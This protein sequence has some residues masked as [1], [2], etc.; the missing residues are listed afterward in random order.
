MRI[1]FVVQRYGAQ[2][3]GGA[4]LAAREFATRLALRGHATEVLTSCAVS[5][6]DWANAYP[7]GTEELDGVLV[8]RLEV[9]E[10]R[11]DRIFG[12]MHARVPFGRHRVP[13]FMQRDWMRVQGPNLPRLTPWLREHAA[14]LESFDP[15]ASLDDLEPLREIVGRRARPGAR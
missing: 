11:E 8:H 9:S 14:I 5:Y 10:P 4:E 3:P 12:P 6:V 15:E 7:P 2:V 1:L 13:P